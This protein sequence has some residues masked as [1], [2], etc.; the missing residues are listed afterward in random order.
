MVIPNIFTPNNDG[1]N[2]DFVIKDLESYPRSQLL[3]FNRWGNEVYRADNYLNNWNGSGLAEGT[4]YYVLNRRERS[5]SITTFK[6]WV[7]LK[8]TK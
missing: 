3:I 5:G 4:Y 8:R 7:Y 6:G 1:K 2:D